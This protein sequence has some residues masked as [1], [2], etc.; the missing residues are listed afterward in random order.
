MKLV[1]DGK[2]VGKRKSNRWVACYIKNKA[3]FTKKGLTKRAVLHE[4]CHHLAESKGL[5][6]AIRKEEKEANNYA[7]T[8]LKIWC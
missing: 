6:I 8:F 5:E 7:K 3:Y 1:L 4:F 2:R